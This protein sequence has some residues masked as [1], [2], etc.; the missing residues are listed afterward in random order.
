MTVYFT[1]ERIPGRAFAE[2]ILQHRYDISAPQFERTRSGKPRLTDGS[3]SFSLSH[4][5][6]R[7]FFAAA[8][9][10]IGIDA[11]WRGRP[12]P[13]AYL[14]RLTPAEREEDFFR[15]WTAKEAYVKWRGGTLAGM[16]PSLRFEGGVLLERG[17]PVSAHLV[18]ADADGY[19]VALC[20]QDAH[21]IR[22]LPAP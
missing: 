13:N 20:M 3:L 19:T 1:D 17:V 7:T 9:E 4:A 21:E 15:L 6:G 10:E 2:H 5:H 16:L 12:L 18:F 11:E 22:L 14:A 8:K